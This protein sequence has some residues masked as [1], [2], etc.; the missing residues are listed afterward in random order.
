ML[1][2]DPFPVLF[3]YTLSNPV[4]DCVTLESLLSVKEAGAQCRECELCTRKNPGFDLHHTHTAVG[5]AADLQWAE[6]RLCYVPS[7]VTRCTSVTA[8]CVS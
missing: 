2:L 3:P 8:V 5:K 1:L 4:P 7:P 6:H